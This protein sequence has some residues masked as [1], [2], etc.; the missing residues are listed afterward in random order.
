VIDTA[1]FVAVMGSATSQI[2]YAAS[3]SGVLALS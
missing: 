2:S 1:S 3:K